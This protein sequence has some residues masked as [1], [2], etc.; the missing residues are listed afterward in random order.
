VATIDFIT[1]LPIIVKQ[2]D[3]VM[4]VVEKLTKDGHFITLNT[5]H[6]EKKKLDIS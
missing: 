1:N 6:K 3:S 4:M 5:T 2:H